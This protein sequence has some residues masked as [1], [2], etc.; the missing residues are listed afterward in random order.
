MRTPGVWPSTDHTSVA[1]GTSCSSAK[2]KSLTRAVVL[3][4]TTGASPVTVIVSSTG[5]GIHDRIDPHYPVALHDD[6][7]ANDR[8][9]SRQLERK[10]IGSASEGPE[11]VGAIDKG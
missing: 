2:P 6:A 9:E 1:D 10:V 8:P 4:S 5:A 11:T 7:F 3:T